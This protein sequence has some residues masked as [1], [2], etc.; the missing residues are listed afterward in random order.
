MKYLVLTFFIGTNFWEEF[1][2]DVRV[3]VAPDVITRKFELINHNYPTQYS[4]DNYKLPKVK[5]TLAKFS[6][7]YRAP[8]IWNNMIPVKMKKIENF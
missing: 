3:N 4:E 1:L 2:H 8:H 5:S 7:R 6:I